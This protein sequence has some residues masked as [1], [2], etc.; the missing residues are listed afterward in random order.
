MSVSSHTRSICTPSFFFF[1][2]LVSWWLFSFLDY[3]ACWLCSGCHTSTQFVIVFLSCILSFLVDLVDL[4]DSLNVL[5]LKNPTVVS[6]L[7][8]PWSQPCV[9]KKK[10]KKEQ[11]LLLQKS[12]SQNDYS[13]CNFFPVIIELLHIDSTRLHE[14][15]FLQFLVVCC[16]LSLWVQLWRWLWDHLAK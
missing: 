10:R 11:I 16:S 12:V 4:V 15:S 9:K 8:L 14:V 7:P 2:L 6:C 3:V 1:H 13:V 5:Y